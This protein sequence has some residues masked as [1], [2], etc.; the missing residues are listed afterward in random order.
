MSYNRIIRPKKKSINKDKIFNDIITGIN[1][2]PLQNIREVYDNALLYEYG[3]DS[4]VEIRENNINRIM[5]NQIRHAYSNYES[6]LK[7]VNRLERNSIKYIQYR[8]IVLERI[9]CEYPFLRRECEKQK[10]K[11][12]MV[13]IVK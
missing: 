10:F 5:V 6:N 9:A 12:D 1:I 2:D 8:N 3:D 7:T 13:K 4:I 11:H